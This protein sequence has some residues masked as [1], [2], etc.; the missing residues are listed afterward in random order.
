MAGTPGYGAWPPY[1]A[2]TTQEAQRAQLEAMLRTLYEQRPALA[3]EIAAYLYGLVMRGQL[4]DPVV[5]AAFRRLY[6]H[7][8]QI[9][10][11]EAGLRTLSTASPAANPL[12]AY[13][14]P[15]S[16]SPPAVPPPSV[17]PASDAEP[18]RLP[19]LPPD[20]APAPAVAGK[21][22]ERVCVHCKTPLRAKDTICPVCGLPADRPA[23]VDAR[24]H[25]CGNELKASD[26][27]C[28]VC[29]MPRQ[30]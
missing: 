4:R 27:A 25:R 11:T 23:V 17:P 15:P 3:A 8:Q 16:W 13:A 7:D 30:R 9:Q 19:A 2:P 21:P 28:P 26:R 1:T 29:G 14:P 10:Q 24:C 5:V 22:G 18:D 12:P 20:A 6:E